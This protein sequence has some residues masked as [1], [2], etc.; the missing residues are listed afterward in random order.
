MY[1]NV[2]YIVLIVFIGLITVTVTF[3]HLLGSK[4]VCI[5]AFDISTVSSPNS[6]GKNMLNNTHYLSVFQKY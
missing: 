5:V 1:F 2:H 4:E 6:L 3:D